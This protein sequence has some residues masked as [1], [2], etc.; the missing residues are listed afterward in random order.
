[1]KTALAIAALA[2]LTGPALAGGPTM[3]ADDPMPAAAPA[4]TDVHDWSGPYVGLSYG[5]TGGDLNDSFADFELDS[6]KATGA[7]VGYNIQRG[8]MV[9]GGELAY[10]STD[11]V[12]IGGGGDDTF[13]SML[14]LRGRIGLSAGKVLVYGAL[15]Y[16]R[17]EMTINGTDGA[18][19]SGISYGVGVDVAV[20]SRIFVGID[21]TRRNLDGRNDADTFDLDTTVN[22]VGL[23]VGLSF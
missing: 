8:Q 5:K 17:A 3:V 4:A 22:T 1:M 23:R 7:F 21:Y 9:Y 11:T 10:A 18:T 16:S 20:S 15:G 6:D 2:A 14:D 12:V 13:D 19:L